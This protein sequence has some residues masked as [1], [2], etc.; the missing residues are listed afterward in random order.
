MSTPASGTGGCGIPQGM[1][2]PLAVEKDQSQ[3]MARPRIQPDV[4]LSLAVSWQQSATPVGF[5]HFGE[6]TCS[7]RFLDS[8]VTFFGGRLQSLGWPGSGAAVAGGEF[9]KHLPAGG[10]L[11]TN[12][13]TLA[14]LR[15]RCGSDDA[16]RSFLEPVSAK[17]LVYGFGSCTA[18]GDVLRG[19]TAGALQK[20]EPPRPG[21]Y[22]IQV[23]SEARDVCGP[24][25]GMTFEGGEYDA[26]CTFGPGAA[27]PF[28]PLLTVNS[29]PFLVLGHIGQ[30][31]ML[32]LASD[33]VSD[34]EQGRPEGTTILDHFCGLLPFLM[35]LRWASPEAFW[36][37]DQPGA[38]FI[39]DDPLLKRR[40]GFLEYQ[41]LADL[42]EREDFCTS[43]GFIPWN[44][45]RSNRRIVRSRHWQR[46]D[47]SLC[48]HGCDHTRGE[49][50]SRDGG[51]LR[52][53]SQTALER[54]ERHRQL[55]GL[56]FDDVMVF[57]QGIFASPAMEALQ[58]CRYLAAVNSTPYPVDKEGSVTLADLLPPAVTRFPGVP[59]FLR[60]SP[61]DV[62]E[63]ACDLFLG[64]PALMVEHHGYFRDGYE[65][66]ARLIRTVRS[67]DARLE[68][69]NLGSLC[70]RASWRRLAPNGDVHVQ[71]FTDRSKI[72]NSDKVARRHLLC[73]KPGDGAVAHQ[74]RV[75]GRPLTPQ[76]VNAEQLLVAV[77]LE[78]GESVEV[79]V[80]REAPHQA[81]A[82]AR[83]GLWYR[84]KVSWRRRLSEFRDNFLDRNPFLSGAARKLMASRHGYGRPS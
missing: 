23:S 38:C 16:L 6:L 8:L 39:I 81:P 32:L 35:F 11:I 75:N 4:A 48:V 50:G 70:S 3:G 1:T 27:S 21:P 58:A 43:I 78:P 12:A 61:A 79:E 33:H 64:K 34:I 63:L 84:T 57:P 10:I 49:F 15:H 66:L 46:G 9:A 36:H 83:A 28:K 26:V 60:R 41:K 82:S 73:S 44:Y 31:Q 20:V 45:R 65:A 55:T 62:A 29:L 25:T 22:R 7:E 18:G 17:V 76:R 52:D 53:A 71:L 30:C 77:T 19:L 14:E 54:M 67:L 24:L 80:E 56:A 40:Y 69:A 42:M 74:V 13:S 59:L 51:R 47:F 5:L 68:W 72:V 2:F 37:H